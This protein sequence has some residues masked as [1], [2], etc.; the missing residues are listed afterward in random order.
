MEQD[1]KTILVIDDNADYLF[2]METF[3][4][5]NGF[6]VL[7]A[8]D[9]Q[10]ALELV[11]EQAPDLILLDVMMESLYSGF[12]ICRR[13]RTDA[14]L[15]EIPII[16]ISGMKDELGVQIDLHRDADYFSPDHFFDKPV[17]KSELLRTIKQLLGQKNG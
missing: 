7:T 4:R 15:A 9:G 11:K 16:G 3:L 8:A 2:T 17:D 10:K 14:A 6:Q 12:E 5:R 13:L 1:E